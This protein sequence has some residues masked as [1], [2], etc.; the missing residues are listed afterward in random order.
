MAVYRNVC[1][2]TEEQMVGWKKQFFIKD[3]VW[4]S[5]DVEKKLH[6]CYAS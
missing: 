6:S 4:G 2:L 5:V 3:R 1:I